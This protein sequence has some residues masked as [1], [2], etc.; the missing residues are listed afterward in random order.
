MAR[1][2]GKLTEAATRL[3]GQGYKVVPIPADL[4][5]VESGREI[6]R[7]A[8]AALGPITVLH[9]NASTAVAGDLVT[10]PAE[11]LTAALTAGVVG[12]DAAIQEAL[13]DMRKKPDP[14]VL[15]TNGG[16]GLFADAVDGI[17][18]QSKSMCLAIANAAKHKLSRL[19][20]RRLESE[21]VFLAEVM[22]MGTVKGTAWDQGNAT[23]EA[24]AVADRFWTLYENRREHFA[25]IG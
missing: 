18:V 8:R 19:L 5:K 3:Q 25:N 24:S 9:W 21:G 6:V 14:A 22:V 12:L 7:K 11:E 23:L 13:P 2:A 15:V 1:N 16:F 10:A 4:T 20:A 17:A